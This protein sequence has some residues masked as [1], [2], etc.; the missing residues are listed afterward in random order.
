MGKVLAIKHGDE[1]ITE[2]VAIF[3]IRFR[4]RTL[5]ERAVF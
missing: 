2:Q 3:K 1:L 5:R 4:K